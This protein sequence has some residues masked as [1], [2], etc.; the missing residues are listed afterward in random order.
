MKKTELIFNIVSIPV[1]ALMIVLAGVIA[2]NLREHFTSFVGP[3]LY[4]L[5]L[6]DYLLVIDKILPVAFPFASSSH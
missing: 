6:N 1:D 3:I 5:N 4:Q 2:F